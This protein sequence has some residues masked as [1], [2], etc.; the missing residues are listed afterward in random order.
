M[1][2]NFGDLS[3]LNLGGQVAVITGASG[4]IGAEIAL[5]FAL[6]G[7]DVVLHFH[8]H[9]EGAQ[10]VA[11]KIISLG[12]KAVVVQANLEQEPDADL[13]INQAMTAFGHVDILVNNAG[14]YPSTPFLQISLMEWQTVIQAN[15]TTAFLCTQKAARRMIEQGHGG[16]IINI[17][18]IEALNPTPNHAHYC[19][20]KAGLLMLT[21]TTARELGP[22]G[23]RVNAVSP[24]LIW[25]EGLEKA[26]SDG[27]NRW[28]NA[29]PLQRLGQPADVAE[30]CLFLA[31]P[32]A[33]WITGENLVVDGGILTCQVY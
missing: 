26:W 5:R 21:R 27:V 28:M 16:S 4:G 29:V 15:L 23:I 6:A 30:A 10:S 1:D 20:A 3:P 18:S 9:A 32:A 31:S 22:S 25:K 14:T 17:A 13:L 12:K 19:A 33:R 2:Q 24:G 7:A 11:Q 8:T